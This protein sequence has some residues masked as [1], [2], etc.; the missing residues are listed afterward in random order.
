MK[1]KVDHVT[2]HTFSNFFEGLK[3]I[4]HHSDKKFSQA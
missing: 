3:K 1:D 2:Y 4:F